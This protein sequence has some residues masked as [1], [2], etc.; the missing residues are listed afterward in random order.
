MHGL[1][2]SDEHKL[3]RRWSALPLTPNFHLVGR[4]QSRIVI[5]GKPAVGILQ[6]YQW[7]ATHPNALKDDIRVTGNVTEYSL[8]NLPTMHHKR[9]SPRIESG[10]VEPRLRSYSSQHCPFLRQNIVNCLFIAGNIENLRSPI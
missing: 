2:R 10:G 4:E 1:Y 8:G 9:T 7:R 6:I 3:S 5:S